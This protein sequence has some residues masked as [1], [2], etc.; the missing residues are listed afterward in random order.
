ME[1][2]FRPEN[3]HPKYTDSERA[4]EGYEYV[5]SGDWIDIEG[6]LTSIFPE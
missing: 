3:L 6:E 2:E 4:I 1:N 5:D